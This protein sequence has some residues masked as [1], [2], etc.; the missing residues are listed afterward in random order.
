[1]FQF[2][3]DPDT[4]LELAL[5]Y[6]AEEIFTLIDRNRAHLSPWFPWVISTISSDDTRKFLESRIHQLASLGLLEC[7]IIYKNKVAG[8][9]GISKIDIISKQPEIGY[10]LGKEFTGKGI[11]TKSCKIMIKYCFE[12]LKANSVLIQVAD[13]NNKSWSVAERLGFTLDGIDRDGIAVGDTFY[14]CRRY[15]LLKSEFK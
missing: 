4:A 2:Q 8:L 12:I 13:E 15:S 5:P 7:V 14:N 6:R 11:V 1:M 3:V 9:I 10:W